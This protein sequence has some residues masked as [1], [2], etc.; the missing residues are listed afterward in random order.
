[1]AAIRLQLLMLPGHRNPG[2]IEAASRA[3]AALGFEITGKG[4]TSLSVR[5]GKQE[6]QQ[7]FAATVAVHELLPVPQELA[8]YVESITVAPRHEYL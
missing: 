2:S 5:V 3:A 7:L 4:R 1:M 8:E 6:F